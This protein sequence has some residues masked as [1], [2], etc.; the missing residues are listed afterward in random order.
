M[1]RT[2]TLGDLDLALVP[3]FQPL[4]AG[5]PLAGWMITIDAGHTVRAHA[6]FLTQELFAHDV[7]I[8]KGNQPNLMEAVFDRCRPLLANTPDHIVEEY[9]R[10]QLR[11]WETCKR[12]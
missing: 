7:M 10:G 1:W 3:Q 9:D 2:D 6:R 5:L 8:V 12:S 11:R 4:L